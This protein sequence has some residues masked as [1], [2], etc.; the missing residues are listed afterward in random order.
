MDAAQIESKVVEIVASQFATSKDKISR[1]T[2]FQED[3]NG[4]S[5]DTVEFVMELEDAFGIEVPDSMADGIK[6]VGDVIDFVGKAPKKA[7]KA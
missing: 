1:T 4:D 7:P 2:R 5:L 6:T 3:L